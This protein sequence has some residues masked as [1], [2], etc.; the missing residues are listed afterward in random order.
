MASACLYLLNYLAGLLS[1]SCCVFGQWQ[2]FL[3][4]TL[5]TMCS[6]R[7]LLMADVIEYMQT[8]EHGT[9][10]TVAVITMCGGGVQMPGP[11]HKPWCLS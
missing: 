5:G 9:Q 7:S 6:L 8:L 10:L 4:H 11:L 3:I 1:L 2:G